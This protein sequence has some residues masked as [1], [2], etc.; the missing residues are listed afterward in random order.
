MFLST[1]LEHT[2]LL[3]L[4]ASA[5]N[6]LYIELYAAFAFLPCSAFASGVTAFS[7]AWRALSIAFF[8]SGSFSACVAVA[9]CG[10][11]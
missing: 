10:G 9:V 11:R 2:A 6:D 3:D 1:A 8:F 4:V 7:S 5:Q